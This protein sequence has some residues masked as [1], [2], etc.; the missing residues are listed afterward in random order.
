[1]TPTAT[2]TAVEMAAAAA[3]DGSCTFPGLNWRKP[4]CSGPRHDRLT[5]Y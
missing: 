5:L 3:I 1:M 4:C 2:V